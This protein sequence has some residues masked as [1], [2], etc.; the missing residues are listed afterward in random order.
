MGLNTPEVIDALAAAARRTNRR[1]KEVWCAAG[2]GTL[3]RALKKAWPNAD[4]HAVCVGHK[5]TPD[6]A[7]DSILHVHPLKFAQVPKKE[8]LPPYPSVPNYDAKTW[9][10]ACE[11]GRDGA[12]IWNVAK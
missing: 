2:S 5:L 7:G 10:V 9:A 12:L 11:L 6:E 3:A 8:D 1:P 4:V